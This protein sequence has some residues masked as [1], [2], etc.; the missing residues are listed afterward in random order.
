MV[1]TTTQTVTIDRVSNG[2]NS[3]AQ[4]QYDGKSI[5][6]PAGEVGETYEVRLVD[7]GGFFEAQLVDRLDAVQPRGP[8]V[9]PDTSDIGKDL[10]NPER[11]RSHSFKIRNSP[12]GGKLRSSSSSGRKMRSKLSRRKK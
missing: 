10:L 5:H 9:G 11:N 3:I 8:S 7:K 1:T 4:Q 6:V 12:A 2:G